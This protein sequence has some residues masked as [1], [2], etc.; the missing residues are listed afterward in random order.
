MKKF[1]GT[2]K[3]AKIL[4]D[5]DNILIFTHRRPDFDTIG[6]ALALEYALKKLGKRAGFVCSDMLSKRFLLITERLETKIDFE[7]ETVVCVDMATDEMFGDYREKYADKALLSID[8]HFSCTPYAEYTCLDSE[9]SATGEIIFDICKKLGVLQDKTLATYLYSAIS[10]DSGC[11]KYSNTTP[12]THKIAASLMETGIDHAYLDRMIHDMRS[13]SM[14]K[15][16]EL[17]LKTLKYYAGGKIAVMAVTLNMCKK[18]KVEPSEMDAVVQL[19]RT[20]EGVEVGITLKQ[21]EKDKFKVSVRS[22]DYFD[23]TALAGI[24]GGGGH[25][26]ASGFSVC[27][28]DIEALSDEIAANAEKLL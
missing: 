22:N 12:R 5:A 15:L 27:G 19:P 9:A 8:H 17:A 18:S 21:T 13:P 1:I 24:Y 11:F 16:Q 25:I 6:S 3:A 10:S 2:A 4:K 23:A 14:M 7:P 26:R 28:S 20:V